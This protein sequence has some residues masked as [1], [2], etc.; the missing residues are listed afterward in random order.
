MQRYFSRLASRTVPTP[1]A[2][3]RMLSRVPTPIALRRVQLCWFRFR[4]TRVWVWAR[5]WL[6][7]FLQ[8]EPPLDALT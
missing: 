2:L 6:N 1:V 4:H 7:D 5:W 8:R 3:R